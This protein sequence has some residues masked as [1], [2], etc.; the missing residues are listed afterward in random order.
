M[1]DSLYTL[2]Q[3]RS[4]PDFHNSHKNNLLQLFMAFNDVTF[5]FISWSLTFTDWVLKVGIST[6]KPKMA[7]SRDAFIRD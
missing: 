7:Y 2:L 4:L 3:S 5:L 1:Y 6:N